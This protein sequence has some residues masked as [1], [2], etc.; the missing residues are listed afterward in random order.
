MNKERLKRIISM[1]MNGTFKLMLLIT[2]AVYVIYYVALITYERMRKG[3]V[4]RNDPTEGEQIDISDLADSGE[5]APQEIPHEDDS[6][7]M[8]PSP[9][10]EDAG[11][12]PDNEE[13]TYE[14]TDEELDHIEGMKEPPDKGD[15]T[16]NRERKDYSHEGASPDGTDRRNFVPRHEQPDVPMHPMPDERES[17]DSKEGEEEPEER[18][19]IDGNGKM[20]EPPDEAADHDHVEEP[21]N[22]KEDDEALDQHD[23]TDNEP[24]DTPSAGAVGMGR[25]IVENNAGMSV[26]EF[27]GSLPKCADIEECNRMASVLYHIHSVNAIRSIPH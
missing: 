1:A 26:D 4:A 22:S 18:I 21:H 6:A 10:E 16:T 13:P 5:F 17:P 11:D 3:K 9:P 2:V 23:G 27:L 20:E 24:P 15:D 19:V 12:E 14:P 25:E 8:P 7:Y